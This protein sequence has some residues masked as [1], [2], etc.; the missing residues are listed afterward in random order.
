MSEYDPFV[1]WKRISIIAALIVFIS[2][3]NC[4][5]AADII[6]SKDAMVSAAK[7]EASSISVNDLVA[8]MEKGESQEI[9]DIR[10]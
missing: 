10:T 9:L 2:V 4:V 1:E 6:T 7:S 5:S 3:C 8:R